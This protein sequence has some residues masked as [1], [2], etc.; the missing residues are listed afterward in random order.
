MANESTD[1]PGLFDEFPPVS[2]REW[3]EK[4]KTD[5]NGADY[6]EKLRWHTG[7]GID[8][9]PF[10]RRED[11]E[12]RDQPIPIPSGA[13]RWEIRSSIAATTI[14]KANKSIRKALRGGSEA[15]FITSKL[16]SAPG[17]EPFCGYGIPL[18]T[19]S[20][21]MRL[22]NEVPLDRTP[23]H[24]DAGLLSPAFL[25]MLRLW[26]K[27]SDFGA[28]SRDLQGSVLFDL[29]AG[30]LLRGSLPSRP[31]LRDRILPLASFTHEHMPGVRPLAIDTR[32]YHNCGAT[33]IQELGFAVGVAAEYLAIL[34]DNGYSPDDI[35]GMLHFN[36]ATGSSYFLEIAKIRALRLLWGNLLKAFEG[37]PGQSP[38]YIHAET[39]RWNKTVYDPH[40]N[41]LRTTTE[42]MSAALAGCDA[43]TIH[44]FDELFRE[45]GR[46]S[47]RMA[48]NAQIIMREEA[49]LG[50]VRDPAAGSYYIEQLSHTMAR[51]AWRL[52]QDIEQRGGMYNAIESE[53]VQSSIAS[54]RQEKDRAVARRKRVFVG[55]NQ[56]PDPDEK[57]GDE[58]GRSAQT[59]TLEQSD[60]NWPS[61]QSPS[62]GNL[63]AFLERGATLGDVASML[64]SG[65]D[66]KVALLHPYR[67]AR[68]FEELRLAT[69]N[70]P[71]TPK[72]LNLPVGDPNMR[73][74]RSAFSKNFFGCA[75]YDIDD[76]I[77]FDTISKA[78]EAVNREQ[79]DIAVLCSSDKEY[80][81]L[82]PALCKQLGEA[83]HLPLLAV[84]G[85]PEEDVE[86]Y[87]KAGVDLF[88][89]S[90]CNVLETL[91]EVQQKLDIIN[92]V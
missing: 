19:A 91:K 88:I 66:K 41:L 26:Q 3:E 44:P 52:F 68:V 78:S 38:A 14:E 10:Y 27:K 39:S 43:L 30:G 36:V 83:D 55:T 58:P 51:K 65:S 67:G 46:F 24:F 6:R 63:A 42:G 35:A 18:Q 74:V 5:L 32:I 11:L 56:Y 20:D 64:R 61:G 69:E 84:A 47:R 29:F 21:F 4:I 54:S 40:T 31:E 33:I 59:F 28:S 90:G 77:A 48:R 2:T 71:A 75:G 85:Y 45:P 53:F 23:V 72:V 86:A 76:P 81:Q 34:T 49:H 15:L 79:P 57:R 13:G 1:Y 7:E 17:D 89:H 12:K 9:L 16:R 8:P 70:H 60:R 87:R 73:K 62:V 37:D 50:K 22:F 92:N 82:V 80:R 25:G